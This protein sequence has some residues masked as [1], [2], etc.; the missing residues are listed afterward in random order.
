[1]VFPIAEY[2]EIIDNHHHK[3]YVKQFGKLAPMQ[4]LLNYTP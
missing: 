4:G 1:M 2:N 3:R